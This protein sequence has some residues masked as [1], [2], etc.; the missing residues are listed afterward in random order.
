MN[1]NQFNDRSL[2]DA[3]RFGAD[4][5]SA[6]PG[7][8]VILFIIG[9]VI[10]FI[11]LACFA[12]RPRNTNICFLNMVQFCY[13]WCFCRL[14][15][16]SKLN[17]NDAIMRYIEEPPLDTNEFIDHV[18]AN[19]YIKSILNSFAH[20]LPEYFLSILPSGSL[21]EGFGKILP[22]TSVLASDFDIMLIPDAALVGHSNKT[23]SG[24]EKP[25]F[26]I[27]E[28][29]EIEEGF[30]WL[31]LESEY[32]LQWKELCI[33]RQTEGEGYSYL[34]SH[35]VHDLISKTFY[36]SEMIAHAIKRM[37]GSKK[38]AKVHV[39]RNGPA[40]TLKVVTR[41]LKTCGMKCCKN[42]WKCCERE[43]DDVIFYCDFTFSLHCPQW[44][45]KSS[46][47]FSVASYV[48]LLWAIAKFKF[49]GKDA[50]L[51]ITDRV[52]LVM[53]GEKG[54]F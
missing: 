15:C 37:T 11:V 19:E 51:T 38:A 17:P 54:I 53:M 32:M 29:K 31:R 2:Y 50:Y 26:S 5:T 30:L 45:E 47:S 16:A 7:V 24:N 35:K 28:S 3:S 39:E 27:V 36:S 40:F 42:L 20:E 33:R 52:P 44:P 25:L 8:A 46:K 48:V 23:Y 13:E 43:R 21:R 10:F 12:A 41:R 34:A 18:L 9:A 49:F 4:Q 22:S 6:G 1:Q 14:D